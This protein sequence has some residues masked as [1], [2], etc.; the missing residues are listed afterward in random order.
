MDEQEQEF[1]PEWFK[2]RANKN[3]LRDGA[4][5]AGLGT[6]RLNGMDVVDYLY[7][8]GF[9]DVNEIGVALATFS[10]ESLWYMSAWHH[11]VD[12]DGN[13]LSTDWGFP[14]INDKA[15]PEFFP[16]GDPTK[17]MIDPFLQAQAAFKV[18]TQSAYTFNPW[19]A[20]TSKVWLDDYH[21]RRASLAL[22]NY[23]SRRLVKLAKDR[24]DVINGRTTPP[25]KTPNT[26]ISIAQFNKIYPIGT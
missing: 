12:A 15:H 18:Y 4:P 9:D 19:A 17:F 22:L 2:S 14:Q 16:N 26:L 13:I 24:P 21:I 7:R 6:T 8:V 1:E 23:T 10:A 3:M 5:V 11:N 25:T 20:Y